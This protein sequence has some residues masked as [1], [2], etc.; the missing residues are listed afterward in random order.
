MAA[1]PGQSVASALLAEGIFLFRRSPSGAAPRGAF[2]M[3]GACQECAIMID[4]AIRRACQIEVRD[5][6]TVALHGAGMSN[7]ATKSGSLQTS[8]PESAGGTEH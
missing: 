8:A 3:I 5:G 1:M 6:M 2:C 4:G 7:D